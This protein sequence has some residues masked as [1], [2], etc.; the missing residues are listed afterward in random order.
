MATILDYIAWRGDVRLA[1]SPFNDVDALILSQISYLNF[2][3]LLAA[4]F[5]KKVKLSELAEQFRSAADFQARS[6][7]GALINS[8]SVELLFAAGASRRFGA[9]KVCGYVNRISTAEVKQ[10]AALTFD[11]GD[12]H[13]F[14]AFRGTDDTIVGWNEDFNLGFMK[15]VPSQHDALEY[16]NTACALLSGEIRIG[17]HSKGGNLAV[18]AGAYIKKRYRR[19]LKCIY[20]N[21]GPGFLED[22]I[23]L[24]EFQNLAPK[25]H[26]FYPQF[27]I[28]G[29]LFSH[30]G[31]YAVV[32]SE[33]SGIMQHD[34]F[35]WHVERSSFVTLDGFDKGSIVF[36]KTFN[37]WFGALNGADRELFV[38]T[39]F[40]II[41][42]TDA[43]TNSELE[44]NWLANSRKIV[45]ALIALP[46]ET[47]GEVLKII[48]L[49]FH[50]AKKNVPQL[51][52]LG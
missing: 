47:R 42:A 49:L 8:L 6:D 20:N 25:V 12:R 38:S 23:R 50:A 35:S 1:V 39:L 31:G 21:D 28:V 13:K 11:T 48:Q 4:D 32:E 33:Q 45:K 40:T 46:S 43:R 19:R 51:M 15:E 30:I 29:M 5:S 52:G 26:S 7:M 34:P 18:Y 41:Q 16:V 9:M 44:K 37:A 2:D 22:T 36:Q 10:F 27:S 14:I 24:P 17:G 3:G